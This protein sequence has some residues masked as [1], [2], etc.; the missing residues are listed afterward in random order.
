MW[1]RQYL[2]C[3]YNQTYESEHCQ[4][5]GPLEWMPMPGT[6]DGI[7][8]LQIQI[9]QCDIFPTLLYTLYQSVV[10]FCVVLHINSATNTTMIMMMPC[11][12]MS[13]LYI[14]GSPHVVVFPCLI[15]SFGRLDVPQPDLLQQLSFAFGT[16]NLI[17]KYSCTIWWNES[18]AH[19]YQNEDCQ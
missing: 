8:Y 13:F 2:N 19:R 10:R 7:G 6:H 4:S 17:R 16:P 1:H 3:P 18:H 14:L 12:Q 15:V 5:D 9:P 11:I